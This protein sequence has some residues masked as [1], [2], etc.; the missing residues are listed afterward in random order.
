MPGPIRTIVAGVSQAAP[1]APT[2]IAA[3][4][5]ARWTGARLHLVH[6]YAPAPGYAPPQ[7]GSAIPEWTREH[8]NSLHAALEAAAR[9]TPGAQEAVCHSV[10][11]TPWA[12]ILDV[13]ARTDA[14]LV[15]VGAARAGRL[16]TAFLGTT[17]QR[18]LRGAE[19]PVLVVRR[20][21]HR[22]LERVLL[23]GDLSEPSAAVHEEALD[24]VA[25]VFGEPQAARSLMV[26]TFPILPSPLPPQPPD[27]AARGELD[28]FLR[29]RRPRAAAVEPLVRMGQPPE[30]IAAAAEEWKADLLVVGTHA[31]GWAARLALGSVAEAA[32]R[33]APCNVL[34]VPP[35]AAALKGPWEGGEAAED[36]E[37]ASAPAAA[38]PA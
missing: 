4:E 31:R 11:A 19:V 13:A 10:A 35:R 38:V 2:L 23:T 1:D 8:A 32:I 14:G 36:P 21:V 25:S 28:A 26:V 15:V 37:K 16:A 17:A 20:P 5:L 30:E 27:P 22:P 24:T 18:V 3:A 7:M 12:A 6:A 34:A 29:A 9:G 33:D